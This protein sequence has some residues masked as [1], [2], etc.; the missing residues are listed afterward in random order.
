MYHLHRS[1]N[2]LGTAVPGRAHAAGYPPP[3]PAGGGH[4]PAPRPRRGGRFVSGLLVG[5]AV[6]GVGFGAATMILDDDRIVVERATPVTTDDPTID[7]AES[8]ARDTDRGTPGV[9]DAPPTEAERPAGSAT[10]LTSVHDLVVGARPS[11]VAIHT[12]LTQTDVFGRPVQ[13]SR[14]APGSC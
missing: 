13:G 10:L 2:P 5:V 6:T 14:P 1:D 3:P 8:A 12:T 7:A 4:D 11:I 9:P